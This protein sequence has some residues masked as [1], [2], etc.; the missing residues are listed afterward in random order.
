MSRVMT[1]G[2]TQQGQKSPC[3]SRRLRRSAAHSTS[4]M[5][6]MDRHADSASP[7]YAPL[8]DTTRGKSRFQAVHGNWHRW[9]HPLALKHVIEIVMCGEM[10]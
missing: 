6:F 7:Y 1:A 10:E 4:K 5:P 8:I 9:E 3:T 2:G